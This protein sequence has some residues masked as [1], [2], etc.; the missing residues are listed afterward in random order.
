VAAFFNRDSFGCKKGISPLRIQILKPF[1]VRMLG[2]RLDW[3]CKSQ[4]AL[5]FVDDG[6]KCR[7]TIEVGGASVYFASVAPD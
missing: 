6:F 5:R 3:R 1:C 4:W 7:Q 2:L